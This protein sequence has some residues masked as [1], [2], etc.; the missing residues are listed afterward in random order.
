MDY[1]QR[2]F[3]QPFIDNYPVI[4][5]TASIC[6][7][8]QWSSHYIFCKIFPER[9]GKLSANDQ[10]DWRIRLVA[11][12]HALASWP[13]ILGFISPQSEL[14]GVQDPITSL[15]K[16]NHYAFSSES[17]FFFQIGTG[18]FLWDI[19]VSIYYNWG[20]IYITHGFCSFGV[21]YFSLYPF[22]HLWGRFYHGIFEIS[23]PWIHLKSIMDLAK[24]SGIWKTICELLFVV[25]FTGVRIILG[26]YV[27]FYWWQEMVYL[28]V[29][30]EA[31][32]TG[33]VCYYLF[34]N[35]T[36]MSLQLYWFILIIKSALGFEV[37][38]KTK[39]E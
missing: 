1:A 36:L 37:S 38:D 33:I 23:T 9:Y 17:Q 24:Y 11:I 13:S 35:F 8:I 29:S 14:L 18:Y 5:I 26:L 12:S 2:L 19:I 15:I 16:Y 25:T 21:F 4:L 6:F 7:L 28:I 39:N 31:H 3:V 27:S 34:A 30:G 20:V 22:L 32:S 10:L